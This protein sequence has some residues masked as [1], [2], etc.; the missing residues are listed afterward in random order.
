MI[1]KTI[2]LTLS[3]I[4]MVATIA[5]SIA[6]SSFMIMGYGYVTQQAYGSIENLMVTLF[7][8]IVSSLL[9]IGN[10]KLSRS[11]LNSNQE[12]DLH[13]EETRPRVLQTKKGSTSAN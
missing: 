10:F 9:L 8:I 1:Q 6:I 2:E 12:D 3:S 13:E 7:L 4:L 11:W 5:V